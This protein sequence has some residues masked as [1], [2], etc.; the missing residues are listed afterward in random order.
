VSFH[1]PGSIRILTSPERLNEGKYMMSRQAWN[2]AYMTML[3][4]DE[5]SEMVP[6]MNM[7]GILGGLF[8]PGTT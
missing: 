2:D 4:P 3:N 7:D 8:T 6:Y 1:R 5:I